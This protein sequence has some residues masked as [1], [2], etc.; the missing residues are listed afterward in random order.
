MRMARARPSF[1]S[2][3]Q[4]RPRLEPEPECADADRH[5]MTTHV[6][7]ECARPYLY[8][9]SAICC[10]RKR[11]GFEFNDRYNDRPV[12]VH[13]TFM[14]ISHSGATTTIGR[15]LELLFPAPW[16]FQW[17]W[18]VLVSFELKCTLRRAFSFR[19]L[20]HLSYIDTSFINCNQ[21]QVGKCINS[22]A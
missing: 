18:E 4:W 1:V 2:G 16:M 19:R 10:S 9:A 14:A 3:R 15:D 13:K 17:G 11:G 5:W 7:T 6:V 12:H 20:D 22:F 8:N 21:Q